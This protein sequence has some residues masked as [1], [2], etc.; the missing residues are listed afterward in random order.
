MQSNKEIVGY[1]SDHNQQQPI[2]TAFSDHTTD[3]QTSPY[4]YSIENKEDFELILITQIDPSD[5]K[6]IPIDDEYVLWMS[7]EELEN[8]LTIYQ[9]NGVPRK[10]HIYD[11]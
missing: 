6:E 2:T 7:K 1:F 10:K 5:N 8:Q 11:K 4:W 3:S 9:Y